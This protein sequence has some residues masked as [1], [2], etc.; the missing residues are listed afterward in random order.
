M[1]SAAHSLR[2]ARSRSGLTQAELARRLGTSQ[3]AVAQLERAGSNP[4]VRTLERALRAAGH[5]LDL[6]ARPLPTGSVD[7]SLLAGRL[8][9]T[10]GE[11]VRTFEAAYAG[12]RQIARAGARARG[13]LA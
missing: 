8:A 2:A 3:A 12:A 10:P 5:R 11:R 7:E 1:S 6:Y 13:E 4:T 9:M